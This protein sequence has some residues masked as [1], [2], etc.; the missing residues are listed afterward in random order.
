MSDN[1]SDK[2]SINVLGGCVSRDTVDFKKEKYNVLKYAPFVS[3]YTM[4]NGRALNID[5][6][7]FDDIKLAGIEKR[8][9]VLDCNK[10]VFEFLAEGTSDWLLLDIAQIRWNIIKWPKQNI[11]LTCR[12]PLT[13]DAIRNKLQAVIGEEQPEILPSPRIPDNE[14]YENLD[15]AIDRIL[16]LY[17]PEQIILNEY[18]NATQYISRK[19]E[20]KCF[21]VAPPPHKMIKK[22][23]DY[24]KSKLKGCHIIK[25]PDN[26]LAWEGH[27]WGLSAYHYH[28]LHYEYAEKCVDIITQKLERSEEERQIEHLRQLYSEKFA[29]LRE[30][31][32][33]ISTV[34]D[35]DKWQTYSLTFKYIIDNNL[36]KTDEN[37]KTFFESA[38]LAKGHKRI[39]IYGD[40]EITKV[41]CNLLEN[42]T[43]SIEYIVAD[44]ENPVKDY[45]MIDLNS[46]SYPEC[47][48]MLVADIYAFNG[49]E[50]K[51]KKMQLPFPFYNAAEYIKSLHAG[52][53][54]SMQKNN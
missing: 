39:A 15:K 3:P 25:Q 14:L 53:N 16:S 52:N 13:K 33:Q 23:N 2:I 50:A 26:V 40:T 17:N 54:D 11:I 31:A 36:L 4:L 43:V 28:D 7:L 45:K 10:S 47:D 46:A 6:S 34:L 29:A 35:R 12:W 20:L 18:Y 37:G 24:Y 21:N 1:N 22:A 19:G 38:I 41:L 30:K 32:A 44:S 27:R 48:I 5:I 8:G 9:I 42:T 49:I 51:L